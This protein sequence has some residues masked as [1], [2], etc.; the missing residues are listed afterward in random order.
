MPWCYLTSPRSPHAST[1]TLESAWTLLTPQ[2]RSVL[3]QT[4]RNC[5]SLTETLP[6]PTSWRTGS[7]GP[8]GNSDV[9]PD[10]TSVPTTPSLTMWNQ[11][12]DIKSHPHHF[13]LTI[14]HMFY[15][16]RHTHTCFLRFL[17]AADTPA[18]FAVNENTTELVVTAPLDREESERYRLL[19]VCTV[20]TDTVITKLETSLDVFVNDEDDN[21]PYVNGTDTVDI[22]ISFNRTKV[23]RLIK[24]WLG[25]ILVN[26]C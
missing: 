10:S 9:S 11:V 19:L 2:C 17:S 16:F 15:G 21:A 5:A 7:P 8:C 13:L 20:R 18:P 22:V 4:W 1:K 12:R 23:R 26:I 6:T 24:H 25:S 14:F 3:R